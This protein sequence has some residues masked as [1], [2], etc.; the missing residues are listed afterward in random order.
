MK[1]R[2]TD[3]W[4]GDEK[5]HFQLNLNLHFKTNLRE[6]IVYIIGLKYYLIIRKNVLPDSGV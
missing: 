1:L 3:A 2:K 4:V 5:S 6:F